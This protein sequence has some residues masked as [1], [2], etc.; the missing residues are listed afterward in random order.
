MPDPT[1]PA[2]ADP[3]PK[4]TYESRLPEWQQWLNATC[5]NWIFAFIVA[6]AIRHFALE[7]F[8][9][10]TASM[11]PMLYGDPAFLKGDNVL[12]DKLLFRFTGPKRWGVTVFQFPIPEIEGPGDAYPAIDAYGKRLDKPLLRPLMYRNFVKRAVALPGDTFFI[13]GGDIYLRQPDGKFAVSRKPPEIQE[14]M[15]QEIYRHD[16]QPGY[17][18]WQADG[19]AAVSADGGNLSMVLHDGDGV[20]FTQPL[21]NLYLKPGPFLV[22]PYQ[23]GDDDPNSQMSANGS[24]SEQIELSMTRPQFAHKGTGRTGNAWNMEQWAIYRLTSADLDSGTYGTLLN[25]TM[26]EWVGDVRLKTAVVKLEGSITLELAQ[27]SMHHY[28][29]K[30]ESS[31]WNLLGDGRQLAS[32]NDAVAGK[33][34]AFGH[35]DNQLI[36]ALDGREL[37]RIDVPQVDPNLQRLGLR[38]LGTGSITLAAPSLERDVHYT[39]TMAGSFLTD[40]SVAVRQ[41]SGIVPE[42]GADPGLSVSSEALDREA[43]RLRNILSVRAQMLGKPLDQL[44]AAERTGRLG[45]SPETAITAPAGAYLMMGDNSP[46]SFDGRCWGWVP[47]ENLRGR[48]LAVILPPNRW[49]LVR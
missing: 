34:L 24:Q 10:P 19:G 47:A 16:A 11:E 36:L 45:Y 20:R 15:W 9:I 42:S 1:D 41:L 17:L 21:R 38:W 6:M 37:A 39:S 30:L 29:L 3:Q 4:P 46:Q 31:G 25:R 26:R 5:E 32:G 7:A 40:E 28:Q 13:A 48:V 27:G 35:L 12:V 49:R 23:P 22:R 44:T 43:Y 33:A 2:T 18:P 14:A 8:R